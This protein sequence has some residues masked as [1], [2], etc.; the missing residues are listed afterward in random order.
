MKKK[1]HLY[2]SGADKMP[3]LRDLAP[4]SKQLVRDWYICTCKLHWTSAHYPTPH[5]TFT[6][7]NRLAT[8]APTHNLTR[9]VPHYPTCFHCTNTLYITH[10]SAVIRSPS[11][12]PCAFLHQCTPPAANAKTCTFTLATTALTHSTPLQPLLFW[13]IC[14]FLFV[15]Y[16]KATAGTNYFIFSEW[17]HIYPC[18]W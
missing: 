4:W 17:A 8:S 13:E 7:T 5:H 9:T 12:H 1:I 3:F 14:L 2:S 18:S 10:L 11:L 6:Q 15:F 16:L